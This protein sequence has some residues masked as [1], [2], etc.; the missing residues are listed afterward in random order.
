MESFQYGYF[1]A[2]NRPPP[3]QVKHMQNDRIAAT[4]SQKLCLSRLFPFIF[5]D[6]IHA[7]PSIIVYKQL[8][9]ILDLILSTSFRKQWLP[10]L[11]DLS[12]GFHESMLLHFP[13]KMTPKIHFACEYDQ[14]INDFGPSIR[15]WCF[16]YE[17]CHAY[18]KKIALRSNNFKNVPKMLATRYSLKQAFKLSR[19]P[20]MKNVHYAIG[21]KNIQR[22]SFSKQVKQILLSHFGVIDLEKDIIH[23]SKLFHENIEY[24]QS[25]VYITD[26]RS[27]DEQP[28]FGQIFFILKTKEKW[29]LLV[30]TLETIAYDE[31]LFAWEIKSMD[32]LSIIDPDHLKYYY[33]GLDVYESNNASFVS[34]SA[35]LTLY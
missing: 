9:D 2:C 7:L 3:I 25:S 22:T 8:R 34:F 35:R 23:C 19:L 6:F 17:G 5:N 1:D 16:R 28:V 30:D 14:V 4:A 10:V 11:R 32:H 29:W 13:T 26:L 24:R 12:I 20:R 27:F 18:F 33:K 31:K 21:I 15:Q